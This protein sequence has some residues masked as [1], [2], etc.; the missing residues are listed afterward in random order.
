MLGMYTKNM[1]IIPSI[2]ESSGNDLMDQDVHTHLL[3][4]YYTHLM[5]HDCHV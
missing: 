1:Y 5:D 4:N 3:E 2:S